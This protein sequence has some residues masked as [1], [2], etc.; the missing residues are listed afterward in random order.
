MTLAVRWARRAVWWVVAPALAVLVIAASFPGLGPAWEAHS[1][2]GEP[3]TFV[4]VAANCRLSCSWVG[5]WT[6]SSGYVRDDVMIGS[7]GPEVS[8]RTAVPAVD[9]DAE[10]RV[11]PA[12]GGSDWLFRTASVAG[13]AVLLVVWLTSAML[14]LGGLR[15]DRLRRGLS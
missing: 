2:G 14:A 1:G 3:G 8:Y 6:G 7:G 5:T 13:A 10:S 11:F 15:Q 4:A 12:G 9:T